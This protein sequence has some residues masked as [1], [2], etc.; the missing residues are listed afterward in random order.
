M[1]MCNFR[2]CSTYLNDGCK[3]YIVDG[4]SC[5][6]YKPLLEGDEVRMRYSSDRFA[7]LFDEFVGEERKLLNIKRSEYTSDGSED[8]LQNFKQVGDFLGKE[9]EEV[10]MVYIIKHLQSIQ[11]AVDT[12]EYDFSWWS[13][14][15]GVEGLKQRIADIRNYLLLLAAILDEKA[16]E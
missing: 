5:K 8:C 2:E 12:G 11:R 13:E 10:C 15:R 6:M 3:F 9:P 7:E 16:G 1:E 14:D 4:E